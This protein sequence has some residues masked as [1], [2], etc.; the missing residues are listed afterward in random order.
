MGIPRPRP[1]DGVKRKLH[2]GNFSKYVGVLRPE[3]G[4]ENAHDHIG[5]PDASSLCYPWAGTITQMTCKDI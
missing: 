1:D 2:T 3:K 4:R 5:S